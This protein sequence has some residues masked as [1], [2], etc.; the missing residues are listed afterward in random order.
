MNFV[1]LNDVCEKASSNIAQKDIADNVGNYPIYGASGYIKDIDFYERDIEY[2]AVVKDGAGIGRAMFLPAKSSII[3]TMQY[4]LPKENILPRYLYYAVNCMNLSKYYTGSTIPHIYFKDYKNEKLRLPSIE[5]QK[6]IIDVL[7]KVENLIDNRQQ[8]LN[9]LDDLIESRFI[10]MFGDPVTN[11]MN[12]K[13]GKLKDVTVKITDGE[14]G[15]VPRSSEGYL[16]LMARNISQ[17]N[18]IILDEISYISKKYH[19]KIYARCNPEEGDILLVCI[20]ATIGRVALVPKMKPFSMVRNVAL[21]K[22]KKNL[23]TS[24]FLFHFVMGDYVQSQIN[25]FVH[26]AA[27]AG[28]YTKMI[29]DINV[30]IPPIAPQNEFT[31]FVEQTEKT[32]STIKKS[33]D[34]LNLLKD[35]L[36]QKYFG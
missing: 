4:L 25:H 27:Q 19:D 23:V 29:S 1:N 30:Y 6:K 12:W 26:A 5:Q 9:L 24:K 36:M 32:K 28:L 16:Y 31:D 7:D 21:I 22:P 14:H 15:V 2:V 20:G 35:S 18:Q 34:E 10:E 17:D 33:L 11:P 13:K 3:G 8:Q